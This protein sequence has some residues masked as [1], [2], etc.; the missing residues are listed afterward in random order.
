MLVCCLGILFYVPTALPCPSTPSLLRRRVVVAGPI[1]LFHFSNDANNR[2]NRDRK[3]EGEKGS[4]A[5]RHHLVSFGHRL[6]SPEAVPFLSLSLQN[7][8]HRTAS[9]SNET[10]AILCSSGSVFTVDYYW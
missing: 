5:I 4:G 3:R 1:I 2:A 7:R 10:E 8:V 9:G 6:D